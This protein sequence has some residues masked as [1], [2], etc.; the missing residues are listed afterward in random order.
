[1]IL[2]HTPLWKWF[3]I[4][5]DRKL[6]SALLETIRVALK[7]KIH[8]RIAYFSEFSLKLLC[9]YVSQIPVIISNCR[10]NWL[11]KNQR[12]KNNIS[13]TTHFEVVA[14]Q[15]IAWLKDVSE[16]VKQTNHNNLELQVFVRIFS[17]G[18]IVLYWRHGSV[19]VKPW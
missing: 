4:I 8:H 7:L 17:E 5:I 18:L 19:S 1:M 14:Q 15:S 2:R 16:A 3:C 9:C 13:T 12:I 6:Y 11:R 10:S